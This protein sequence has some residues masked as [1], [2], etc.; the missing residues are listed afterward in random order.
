[1]YCHKCGERLKVVETRTKKGLITREI[2]YRCHYDWAARADY[3]DGTIDSLISVSY[4]ENPSTIR[5]RITRSV[6]RWAADFMSVSGIDLD[7][8]AEKLRQKFPKL[9]ESLITHRPSIDC[10]DKNYRDILFSALHGMAMQYIAEFERKHSPTEP[11]GK[12]AQER[13]KKDADRPQAMHSTPG[14]VGPPEEWWKK[15]PLT[16]PISVDPGQRWTVHG[17]PVVVKEVRDGVATLRHMDK[18][19]AFHACSDMLNYRNHFYFGQE[20]TGPVGNMSS[21]PA[22]PDKVRV[23]QLW[24]H[25]NAPDYRL[26]KVGYAENDTVKFEKYEGISYTF[27]EILDN[28]YIW[29]L[30]S[31]A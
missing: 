21:A 31:E 30:V 16:K 22:R 9:T 1:M 11:S 29:T 3:P 19:V 14:P 15:L 6:E 17:S 2:C 4:G 23:G 12:Q 26:Y 7:R 18:N 20:P 28:P 24:R 10:S 8:M 27:E 25:A 5:D 13:Q